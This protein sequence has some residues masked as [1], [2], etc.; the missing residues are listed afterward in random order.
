MYYTSINHNMKKEWGILTPNWFLKYCLFHRTSWLFLGL[1]T[2]LCENQKYASRILK[3]PKKAKNED[4]NFFFVNLG[5]DTTPQLC[6]GAGSVAHDD[7]SYQSGRFWKVLAD[8]VW[9]P[10]KNEVMR[11]LLAGRRGKPKLIGRKVFRCGSSVVPLSWLGISV[12]RPIPEM[13]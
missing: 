5:S 9:K 6:F 12:S 3:Y 11:P 4:L 8:F 2:F 1:L 13:C 7:I 10:A